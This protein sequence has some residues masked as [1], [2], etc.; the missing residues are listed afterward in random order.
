M[1]NNINKVFSAVI[2][3]TLL[4]CSFIIPAT[5][6]N[7]GESELKFKD[8]KFK[9]LI[10]SDIQDTNT[11]QKATADLMKAAIEKT[12]PDF[13]ALTGDNTAG[14]WK[15]VNKE[16]TKE[17]VDKVAGVIDGY[18][19]PFA[20]VFGNH[21]H[22]G[23][24]DEKNGYTEEQAKQFIL[25]C[26]Q[27]YDTC[28]AVGGEEM[29]GYCNYNLLIK[30]SK[31]EKDAFNMWFMDSNPYASDEEGGGYGYVHEDQIAWYEK[32]AN[33]LKEQNGG[34]VIPSILFQHIAVPEVYDMFTVVDKG[35]K[36][37]VKGHGSFNDK[38]FTANPEYIYQGSLNEGPCPPDTNH[39]QFDSWVKTGDITGAVFG[40]DHVN[41]Y[42]GEYKGIKMIA[43][44]GVGFYSYGN[45]HGVRTIT[46]DESNL[47]DF[48][49]DIIL[50]DE[51]V[52]EKVSNS[53]IANHGYHEYKDIFLP[54]VIGGG[55]GIAAAAAV[56]TVIVKIV[57]KRKIKGDR[58]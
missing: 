1:K 29:T 7:T 17:A 14:W 26:F 20:L 25:E 15:G 50:Y 33:E 35:T 58:L 10:L 5:A 22:E 13:I 8:G 19:I 4:F 28:L 40:H 3:L 24:C 32:T 48:T 2:I 41:D 30:D 42:A 51:L 55:T 47:S 44:P 56:I 54:A 34:S 23:L 11:P 45:H 12:K 39:G 37:A 57:K 31:G 46:L 16:Q 43:A 49:S 36:G 27:Q 6:E 9:I 38:Y 18:G 52:A 21:D 53:Y